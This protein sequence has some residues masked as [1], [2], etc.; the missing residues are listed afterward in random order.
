[1][2]IHTLSDY[3]D[4]QS[5]PN[6][7]PMPM[8]SN[9]QQS[10]G[11][12]SATPS[13]G[14]GQQ[15]MQYGQTDQRQDDQ[16]WSWNLGDQQPKWYHIFLLCCCPCFVGNPCS[17]VRKQDYKRMLLT[18][19]FWVTILDI[20]YFIVEVSIGGVV[21]TQEN[22]AIGP[23]QS[24]LIMLGAKDAFLIK[25]Y[26]QIQRLFVPIIMHA[27]FLHLIMN[28]FVQFTIGLGYER[29]WKIYRMIPIYVISGI[30]GNLLSCV[31]IPNGISV[32]ASGAIMGMIG[33]KVGNIA[34][35]WYKIP[36]QHRIVQCVSI[37]I[38]IAIVMLWGFSSYIDWASHLGGLIMGAF[39]GFAMFANEIEN[40][41]IRTL[42]IVVPVGLAIIYF[43]TLSLIFAL[44]T[45]PT[46]G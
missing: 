33:A 42:F 9:W 5:R 7:S 24:T 11:N 45:T 22:P 46:V 15:F 13:Y 17:P 19:I 25:Y 41:V 37:V 20:I 28:M 6:A 12:N 34:C 4:E 44:V 2:P 43:I 21:S 29:N 14:F 27:G 10:P 26:Y 8:P 39:L 40:R 38:V 3:R 36:P 1:M 16:F 23:S 31:A 30:A 32:G 18:F 35:R